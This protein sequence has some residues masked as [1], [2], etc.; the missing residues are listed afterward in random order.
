MVLEYPRVAFHPYTCGLCVGA[1]MVPVA[2]IDYDDCAGCYYD[3][4]KEETIVINYFLYSDARLRWITTPTL[5]SLL[6]ASSGN[7]DL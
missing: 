3:D 2:L 1:A 7:D 4:Y 5:L 6:S